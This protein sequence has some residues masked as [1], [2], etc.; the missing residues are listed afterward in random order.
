MAALVLH[1]HREVIYHGA[2]I[3]LLRDLYLRRG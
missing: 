2:G 1:I 3:C